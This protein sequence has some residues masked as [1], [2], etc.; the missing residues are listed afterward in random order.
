M[1]PLL[2]AA[3]SLTLAGPLPRVDLYGDPLPPHALARL[4]SVRFQ[5]DAKVWSV[6]FSPDGSKLV[7]VSGNYKLWVWD[8]A[9]GKALLTLGGKEAPISPYA[10]FL[11]DGKHVVA[12]TKEGLT[13]FDAATGKAVR[14]FG[15]ER[16][17]WHVL[18]LSPDGKLLA[19][20]AKYSEDVHLWE[21]AGGKKLRTLPGH[22]K[23]VNALAFAPDG[24]R[25][26]VGSGDGT[27]RLWN[28]RKED[29]PLV[30]TGHEGSVQTVAF[31]DAG[32]LLTGGNDR[33]LRHWDAATGKEKAQRYLLY[34]NFLLA[35]GG[36][37]LAP[38]YSG[39]QYGFYDPVTA[40]PQAEC[41]G[42]MDWILH[43]AYSADGK[44]FATAGEDHVLRL[45]D[46]ATGAALRPT[47]GHSGYVNSVAFLA[48]NETVVTGGCDH[49]LRLWE[50]RTGKEVRLHQRKGIVLA[51]AASPDGRLVASSDNLDHAVH[52]ED[53][54]SGNLVH[55]IEGD[56]PSWVMRFSADGQR[57]AARS[58]E[59]LLVWQAGTWK[60]LHRLDVPAH[61]FSNAL[62][63]APDLAT[64][65]VPGGPPKQPVG[66]VALLDMATGKVVRK[67]DW[68]GKGVAGLAFAPDGQRLAAGGSYNEPLLGWWGVADG[69]FHPLETELR[70]PFCALA[71]SPDG[72]LLAAAN[73]TPQGLSVIHVWDV[74]TGKVV[75][76]LDGHV[77]G[78]GQ[79]A[80]SPNGK[81]LA[82][83]SADR[84]VLVWDVSGVSGAKA[85]DR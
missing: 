82:S 76:R 18:T 84:T 12:P 27:T 71:F 49:E 61:E 67:F 4:G 50:A 33:T 26:A 6:D 22:L 64:V 20:A 47:G 72:R 54:D 69:K 63:L 29:Q 36:K 81:L 73:W 85:K 7:T 32:T 2:L 45:W 59:Q 56:A 83:A 79:L 62:A 3:W 28:L 55:K 51:V 46:P 57:L 11:P 15:G 74:A 43:A 31:L 8:R 21:V 5:H 23:Y 25:L 78:V 17:S 58:K 9:S 1:H 34:Y 68:P 60:L 48:D 65:A 24:G 19:G 39:W 38:W 80:F 13:V 77:G 75:L 52:V 70:G 66:H 10:L 40:Q 16:D 37:Q 35:P 44:I 30:L 41:K 14:G 53:A 42:H